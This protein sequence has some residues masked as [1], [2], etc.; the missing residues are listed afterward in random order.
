MREPI[1]SSQ[2]RP[3]FASLWLLACLC[4]P[5]PLLAESAAVPGEPKVLVQ[6]IAGADSVAPGET[7]DLLLQQKIA[8]GWHTY[9]T[10]PGDSGAAPELA[11]DLPPGVT[12]SDFAYPWPERIPY[13]PL[14]N[15]GY[16]DEVLMPFTATLSDDFK[17]DELLLR[18]NGQVLVCADICIPEKV[19][20]ELAIK[21]ADS[22][23]NPSAQ[24][25]FEQARHHLPMPL[26]VAAKYLQRD[27]RLEAVI[28]LP[29]SRDHRIAQVAWFPFKR[30]LIENAAPQ[31]YA[32]T[33]DGMQIT[34]TP[35]YDYRPGVDLSGILVVH[36][37]VG[38]GLV[39][40]YEI[41]MP[42]GTAP[43][44]HELPTSLGWGVTLM[45]AV[46]FAF[47]GGLI[48]NLMPCVFPVLSIKILSLLESVELGSMK[49]HG[50]VYAAGVV[51]SFLVIAAA[52]IALKLS[53]ENIGWGF[54]LQSPLV[55]GALVYLF[56]AM[57]MNL[58]G[59]FE[60]GTSLMSVGG[61]GEY[62]R[63]S[64]RSS[65]GMGVLATT[66]AAP[67]TAP[68]MGAAIGY[69]LTQPPVFSLLVF[70]SLGAGMAAPYLG[71]CYAPGLVKRLPRPGPWMVTLKEFLAFPMLASA[72]WLVWVLG[73]QAGPNAVLQILGGAL[74]IALAVWVW[75][76][77]PEAGWL[78][79]A[80]VVSALALVAAA[81]YLPVGLVGKG[82]GQ[83]A[84][85]G[86][87]AA[88]GRALPYSSEALAAARQEG[89]AV[90]VN[91]TAAWCI[92]CKVNELTSLSSAR[93]YAA[94]EEQGVAY[95]LADWTSEDPEITKQ[96]E[97][98][99]RSGVPLY[100]YFAPGSERA[101]VLP[102]VLTE[103][104][105]LRTLTGGEG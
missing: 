56:V 101:E 20:L 22:Q 59:F 60:M 79:F 10:N 44:V 37:D 3:G 29:V 77:K 89:S 31:P 45:V 75:A 42:L 18:G 30:D 69:A 48:L 105:V 68:F 74:M 5:L 100:L 65:F 13:G 84:P 93:F 40:A 103:A 51:S 32:I 50:W 54:Q 97:A 25:L 1:A 21:V 95:F 27:D 2:K 6:L 19:D 16:K 41:N 81:L 53:G 96:L 87:V 7:I 38:E 33:Q 72:I 47:L 88:V 8:P 98:Y 26:D 24:P 46:A 55:V 57:G 4:L 78:R 70:A 66:V 90:L 49:Q 73:I 64:L 61:T 85:A 83:A 28:P 12:L 17:G 71:L 15:F 80:R 82:G 92:T 52:L 91:F 39:S 35:G 76:R 34:L 43:P 99:G 67:C 102:Q 14:M 63:D 94:I 62:R 104:L 36:E 23:P 11:F 58:L 86:S 9:W